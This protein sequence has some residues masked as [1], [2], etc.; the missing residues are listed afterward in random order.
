MAARESI[1]KA[2]D[3]SLY[4]SFLALFGVII[5]ALIV[6]RYE[7]TRSSPA[8]PP[9]RFQVSTWIPY[10]DRANVHAAFAAQA[11]NIDEA[12]F[13]WYEVLSDGSLRAFP[14]AE[15]ASLLELARANKMRVLPTIMN[16]FDGPRV[17]VLLADDESRTAHVDAIAALV[18]RM[19]Y[20]GIELDYEALSAETR[21][22]FSIFVEDLAEILHQKGKILSIAVH[23]KTNDSGTWHGPQAQD[24]PRLGAAVDEFKIMVYDYH[25]NTSPPG[26]IAPLDWEEDVLAYAGQ[27]VP[28]EKTWLGIPFYGRDW[29]EGQGQGLVWTAAEKLIRQYRPTTRRDADSGELYFSYTI[30]DTRHTVYLPDSRAIAHKVQRAKQNHPNI[31]GIAIWRLGGESPGHWAAI[32]NER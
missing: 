12:N 28:P 2:Q 9:R 10:W 1:P 21:D 6:A 32:Q 3:S 11:A 25:W 29:A 17:A 18:E 8:S 16:D 4:I 23:P 19:S 24:W 13:F 15:D 26:P 5:L 27:T 7:I 31:A 22:D 14:G 30:S 20:D